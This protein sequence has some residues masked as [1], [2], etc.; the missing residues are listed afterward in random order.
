ML[1]SLDKDILQKVGRFLGHKYA[2]TEHLRRMRIA[3]GK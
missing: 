1:C 2:S 3:V